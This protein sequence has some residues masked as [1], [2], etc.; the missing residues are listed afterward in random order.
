M[1]G[2][3]WQRARG[4]QRSAFGVALFVDTILLPA[5]PRA[6]A[7]RGERDGLGLGEQGGGR[8]E[9]GDQVQRRGFGHHL[10][11]PVADSQPPQQRS[12]PVVSMMRELAVLYPFTPCSA[13]KSGRKT[14][15]SSRRFSQLCC[16][17]SLSRLSFFLFFFFSPTL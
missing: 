16:L 5:L 17:N 13:F 15:L 3:F 1:G 12:V 7:A 9:G 10:L 6:G 14:D 11:H 2:A 4:L 8:G